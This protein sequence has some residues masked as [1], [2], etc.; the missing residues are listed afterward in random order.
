MNEQVIGG[1]GTDPE[2]AAPIGENIRWREL[3]PASSELTC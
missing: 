1:E 2:K 3:N